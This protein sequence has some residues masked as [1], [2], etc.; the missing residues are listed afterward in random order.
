MNCIE[1]KSLLQQL[2]KSHENCIITYEKFLTDPKNELKRIMEFLNLKECKIQ[3]ESKKI[4]PY[5]Q[6]YIINYYHLTKI[7]HWILKK[8]ETNAMPVI[9][10]VIFKTNCLRAR[11]SFKLNNLM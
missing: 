7:Y 1:V 9:F 5:P 2:T 6:Y 8:R 4:L 3:I 11:I 10:N